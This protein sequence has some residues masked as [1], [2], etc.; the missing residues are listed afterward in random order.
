LKDVSLYCAKEVNKL[1]AE[2]SWMINETY[3]G[4]SVAV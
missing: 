3:L 1:G 2:K 4:D